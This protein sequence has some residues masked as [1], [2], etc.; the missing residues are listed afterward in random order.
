MNREEERRGVLSV[1]MNML[2]LGLKLVVILMEKV[3]VMILV[4][5]CPL[6]VMVV[7]WQSELASMVEEVQML[8]THAYSRILQEPIHGIKLVLISMD[9]VVKGVGGQCL[10]QE[11]VVVLQLEV[12][13]TTQGEDETE[14]SITTVARIRGIS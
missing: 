12:L 10:Y 9:L 14:Y 7:T 4:S 13:F 6:T 11:T 3:T 1:C 2:L 8:A 5:Q